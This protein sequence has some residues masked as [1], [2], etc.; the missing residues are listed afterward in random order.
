MIADD[1]PH[2]LGHLVERVT[3]LA[4]LFGDPPARHRVDARAGVEVSRAEP[5]GRA[6]DTLEWSRDAR[7][8]TTRGDREHEE[9]HEQRD[10]EPPRLR[11]GARDVD[12]ERTD[13]GAST[14]DGHV[15]GRTVEHDAARPRAPAAPDEDRRISPDT[16]IEACGV[17]E[18]R[19]VRLGG[20]RVVPHAPQPVLDVLRRDELG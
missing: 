18:L 14:H 15:R 11:R 2:A 4:H 20:H 13:H 16:D 6:R 5:L 10:A 8:H 3:H 19:D 1:A 12:L 9:R 7:R 17:T